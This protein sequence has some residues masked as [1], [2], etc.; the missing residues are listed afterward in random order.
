M[1]EPAWFTAAGIG[2][3]A[4][5]SFGVACNDRGVAHRYHLSGQRRFVNGIFRALVRAGIAPPGTY[6]LTVAGRRSGTPRTT[7]VTLVETDGVRWLV[8]PYG[9]VGWVLNVRA[10][11]QVHLR[12]G[13]RSE[14]LGTDEVGSD[15]A[16]DVL[17]TYLRTVRVVRPFF[18]VAPDSPHEAFVAEAHRHPVFRLRATAAAG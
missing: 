15:E 1:I 5:V 6:L 12:R 14:S 18:D 11:G 2:A 17:Q 16:A 13:R 10:A 7:P 9:A 4:D 3:V 8:A